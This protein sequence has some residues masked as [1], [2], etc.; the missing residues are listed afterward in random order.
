[1]TNTFALNYAVGYSFERSRSPNPVPGARSASGQFVGIGADVCRNAS[2]FV[3]DVKEQGI[4]ISNGEFV[5][6]CD[7]KEPAAHCADAPRTHLLVGPGN[8]G[9]VKLV[10][11]NFWGP[12][13]HVALVAGSGT[14]S[15]SGCTALAWD[16]PVT[17]PPCLNCTTCGTAASGDGLYAIDVGGNGSALVR[18]NEFKQS[19][20]NQVRLGAHVRR[21]VVA[22]NLCEGEVSIRLDGNG[23]RAAVHDNVH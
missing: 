19:G 9:S 10:N 14:L 23:T 6:L 21:A 17:S 12:A 5:T 22:D 1:M 4:L 11:S 13:R 20:S 15:L 7:S 16:C 8:A 3:E 18:G 2:V